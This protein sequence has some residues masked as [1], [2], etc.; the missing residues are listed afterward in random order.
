MTKERGHDPEGSHYKMKGFPPASKEEAMRLPHTF[1]AL[2][3]TEERGHDPEGSHYKMKRFPPASKEEAMR[4]P[5]RA[6]PAL[7]SLSAGLS[8]RFAMTK[9]GVPDESG[10]YERRHDPE[11]VVLQNKG[12]AASLKRRGYEIAAHLSGARKDRRKAARL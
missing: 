9:S 8:A 11:G 5:H 1:Q 10:N 12:I 3:M 2:A 4:L 6:L 7:N